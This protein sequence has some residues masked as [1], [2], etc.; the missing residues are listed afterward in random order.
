MAAPT[1]ASFTPASLR[2]SSELGEES[3]DRVR[4]GERDPVVAVQLTNGLAEGIPAVTRPADRDARQGHDRRSRRLE[5][6]RK[7]SRLVR[8]DESPRPSS[9][10]SG[11]RFSQREVETRDR[12]DRRSSP[13]LRARTPP[14]SASV[15]RTVRWFLVVPHST[16]T[17]GVEGGRP[18]STSLREISSRVAIPI[19]T[20][21]VPA[22]PWRALPS[23]RLRRALGSPTWPVTIVTEVDNPRWVTGHSRIR[24][25]SERRGDPGH[26][27]DVHPRLEQ[28]LDL[29][30]PAAEQE[31][32][33]T[34]QADHRL[35]AA[36]SS[37]RSAEISSW[38]LGAPGLLPTSTSRAEIGASPRRLSSINLSCTT[39]S[40][41]ASSSAPRTVMSPGSPGPA[42]TR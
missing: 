24:G 8:R 21:I 11:R 35:E 40:A 29:L 9:P 33:A 42:P 4:R 28:S 18:P 23:R 38:L 19:R 36:A 2:A 25:R 12:A 31:G 5:T 22:G 17:T 14:S 1:A 26:D 20:T 32:V 41:R 10:S 34:L 13:A 39:T 27:L 15:V 30:A 3:V 37:I 6:E 16:T 7:S